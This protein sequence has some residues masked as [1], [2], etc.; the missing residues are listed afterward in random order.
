MFRLNAARMPKVKTRAAH[1]QQAAPSVSP[2]KFIHTKPGKPKLR[3]IRGGRREGAGKNAEQEF[4]RR[5]LCD[6]CEEEERLQDE[7]DFREWRAGVA[8]ALGHKNPFPKVPKM[9]S[10][11]DME[12]EANFGFTP[13]PPHKDFK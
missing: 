7:E 8:Y 11:E 10:S 4:G 3:L 2:P 6:F 1:N 5:E 9:R 13:P 12:R